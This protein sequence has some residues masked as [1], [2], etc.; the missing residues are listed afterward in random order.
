MNQKGFANIILVVVIVL[1]LGAV[2]YFAFVK[3][4]EPVAQQSTANQKTN[5]AKNTYKGNGIQIYFKDGFTY[6][7]SG[8]ENYYASINF[9]PQSQSKDTSGRI[10]TLIFIK[11]RTADDIIKN[12]EIT[13]MGVANPLLTVKPTK[14]V[15]NGLTAI[16][17]A[18]G[19]GS[20]ENRDT[21]IIGVKYNYLL[22]SLGC[23][24]TQEY[25]FNYLENIID[26]AKLIDN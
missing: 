15:K 7:A 11:T 19:G 3:K 1:L 6:D 13:E 8:N 20:C 21:E 25:D 26:N 9:G 12:A 24:K 2:G 5:D 14:I 22:Y 10:Y 18:E 23:E 16:K 4:S 17:W